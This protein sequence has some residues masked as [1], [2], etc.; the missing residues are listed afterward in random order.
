MHA[1]SI[2]F[3][4]IIS[5]YVPYIIWSRNKITN[6]LCWT[7]IKRFLGPW[8]SRHANK[9]PPQNQSARPKHNYNP[10]QNLLRQKLKIQEIQEMTQL[11]KFQIL[12]LT[13]QYQCWMWPSFVVDSLKVCQQHWFRGRGVFSLEN[14]FSIL[15]QQFCPRL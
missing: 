3:D 13:P 4:F 1:K 12:P 8:L 6:Y 9:W 2:W 7:I 14:R 10:G 5:V 15:S 11:F